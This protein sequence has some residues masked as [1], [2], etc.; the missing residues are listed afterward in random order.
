MQNDKLS[1]RL[2]LVTGG[3]GFM[4][5]NLVGPLLDCRARVR[6][7]ARSKDP[8]ALSWLKHI[9]AGRAVE[10]EEGDIRDSSRLPRWLE[11]VDIVVSLAGESGAL[12]SL[13]EAHTDIQT[14]VMGHLLLLDAVRKLRKPPRMI[15]VSSRLVYGITGRDTVREDHTTLPTSL[16]GLHKLAV[17]HYHRLYSQHYG[18]PYSI[19]RVTNSY[20]PYQLPH[21]RTHGIVNQFISA[22]LA[23]N[24]LTVYGDG[25]QLRDY[26]HAS[27]VALA[28]ISAATHDHAVRAIFN[29][30]AGT[31]VRLADVA[32]RIVMLAGG[33]IVESAPWPDKLL[34]VETG[35]FICDISHAREQLGWTPRI[36]LDEGLANT[37]R[38]YR[39]LLKC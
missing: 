27:D 9:A 2:V 29:V 38:E 20:G 17:E 18:I 28:V 11:D 36:E 13:Q 30:G 32:N 19:L 10:V 39:E 23:G 31:S 34:K 21:R 1:G 4:G 37:V 26:V 8:L 25:A 12:K 24:H 15:F 35:D 33:G 5:L 22:A 14:N 3:L 16:Y 6:I 7:L